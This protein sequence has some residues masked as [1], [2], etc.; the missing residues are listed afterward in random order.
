MTIALPL[1]QSTAVKV[2]LGPFVDATDGFTPETGVTL[3]AADAAELLK[4]DSGSVVDISGSTFTHL[5]DGLY[6]LSLSA[7]NTDT[8]GMLNI[9]IADTSVCRPVKQAFCVIPSVVW[10]SFIGGS[11]TIPADVHQISG[12]ATAADNLEEAAKAMVTGA[13]SGGSS[14]TTVTN[15]NLTEATNDHYNGRVIVFVSGALAGQAATIEDYNGSTKAITHAALTE[16]AGSGDT[17]VIV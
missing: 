17:F 8:V 15:T 1:R 2:A 11:D 7:S 10:D 9:Y 5:Q 12:S 16:A 4:H 3:A 6:N 14:T 13:V